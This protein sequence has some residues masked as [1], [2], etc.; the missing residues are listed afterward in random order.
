M[1]EY[2]LQVPLTDE[3]VVKLKIG[4]Q[5]YFSGPAFTCRS[6]LQK[7]IFDEKNTLPF[8]TEKRNLL[9][10]VGPIVVKEKDDWRLVSFT[11]TS[12]IRF[13]KWGAKSVKEWGL[14]AII[15]KTTMGQETAQA[16]KKYKCVHLS[17]QSV[18]PNLWLDSIKIEDVYLFDEL[19]TI[20]A[21]WQLQLDKLGPFVVD[22]DCEGNNYFEKIDKVVEKNM[23]EA[24]K[25]LNIPVDFEYTKLY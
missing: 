20:E 14:K 9:I 5:V 15:G 11:P 17:P 10:H 21:A 2:Y 12:S 8:S 3:D 25:N 19:G 24:Y 7:Y 4:D 16:M 6:R 23:Q 18:S 22:I 13:E 1:A